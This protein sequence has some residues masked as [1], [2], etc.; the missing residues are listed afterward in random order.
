MRAVV[1][2]ALLLLAGAAGLA[3]TAQITGQIGTG[4][5]GVF[6]G[7]PTLGI[8]GAATGINGGGS[9]PPT[10]AG[11]INLSLGCTTPMLGGL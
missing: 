10:C 6:R 1:V 8:T 4:S 7:G 2:L 9:P 5:S 3:A 11:V